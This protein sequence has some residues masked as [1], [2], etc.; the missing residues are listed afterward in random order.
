MHIIKEVIPISR[1][2]TGQSKRRSSIKHVLQI[3]IFIQA[4]FLADLFRLPYG[5]P[6]F[7]RY[8]SLFRSYMEQKE[9]KDLIENI[10]TKL[11]KDEAKKLGLKLGRCPTKMSI[12]KMLPEETVKKLAKK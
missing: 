3:R 11:L 5:K 9:S 6:L 1:V 8:A 4:I 2:R 10:D 7:S 12:A